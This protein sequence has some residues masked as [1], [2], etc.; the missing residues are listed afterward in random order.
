MNREE[1]VLNLNELR[2]KIIKID[3]LYFS[4]YKM[5]CDISNF[6]NRRQAILRNISEYLNYY[7]LS[8]QYFLPL[9]DDVSKKINTLRVYCGER[10][11][12]QAN[13]IEEYVA[14]NA[15]KCSNSGE[16]ICRFNFCHQYCKLSSKVRMFNNF[17]GYM[18]STVTGYCTITT[19]NH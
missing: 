9:L 8:S 2:I 13:T 19:H 7:D 3:R 11:L 15:Y 6:C 14:L 12:L 5:V 4:K 16:H 1:F 10:S 17:S 18:S